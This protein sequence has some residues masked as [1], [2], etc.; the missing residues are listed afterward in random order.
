MSDENIPVPKTV[1]FLQKGQRALHVDQMIGV[2]RGAELARVRG[3]AVLRVIRV[4]AKPIL[5]GGEAGD[6]RKRGG[7]VGGRGGEDRSGAG[8]EADG[9]LCRVSPGATVYEAGYTHG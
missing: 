7:G 6:A 4:R 3:V 9:G 8:E 1:L 2:F 5:D